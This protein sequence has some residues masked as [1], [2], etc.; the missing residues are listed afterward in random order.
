MAGTGRR[1]CACPPGADCAAGCLRQLDGGS[2][3]RRLC[4]SIKS[5]ACA[6][7]SHVAHSRSNGACCAAATVP[8]DASLPGR[9][10]TLRHLPVQ[11]SSKYLAANSMDAELFY[12][13]VLGLRNASVHT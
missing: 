9:T 5:A 3:T 7:L 11:I 6:A 12:T 13:L 10:V 8:T 1:G 2:G 4:R